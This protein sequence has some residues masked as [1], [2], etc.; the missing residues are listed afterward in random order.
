MIESSVMK[1][2]KDIELEVGVGE[3]GDKAVCAATGE[4]YV[5]IAWNP[6][7]NPIKLEGAEGFPTPTRDIAWAV[8][9]FA[10]A[11]YRRTRKGKIHW[12][13]RPAA[14][15]AFDWGPDNWGEKKSI[16][17]SVVARLFIAQLTDGE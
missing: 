9:F 17:Y 11:E 3:D 10:F 2:I 7:G 5:T 6:D 16:G 8:W 15:E 12:R 4:P 13:K 14:Y 1:L